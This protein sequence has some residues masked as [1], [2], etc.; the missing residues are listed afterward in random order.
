M[1]DH[2]HHHHHIHRPSNVFFVVTQTLR[3]LTTFSHDR[4]LD[5]LE[6]VVKY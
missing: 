5:M 1:S 4:T 2:H 3:I 6:V